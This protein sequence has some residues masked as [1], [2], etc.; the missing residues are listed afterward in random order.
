MACQ[1][2]NHAQAKNRF[3]AGMMKN[4]QANQPGKEFLLMVRHRLIGGGQDPRV[5]LPS[6]RSANGGKV[7][8]RKSP[9]STKATTL[10]FAME[11][12]FAR[13]RVAR[14]SQDISHTR[15]AVVVT[16]ESGPVG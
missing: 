10:T 3:M 1:L 14:I 13:H 4:V 16:P 9:R 11:S 12:I 8:N 15:M 6:R 5:Y 2:F 7:N